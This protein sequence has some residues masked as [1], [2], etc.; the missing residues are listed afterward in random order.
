MASHKKDLRKLQEQATRAGFT[1]RLTGGGHYAY[2]AP[3]GSWVSGGSQTPSDYRA[4]SNL[5]S[6]LRKAGLPA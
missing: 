2:Y 1:V 6:R 5:R 3:D 4:I